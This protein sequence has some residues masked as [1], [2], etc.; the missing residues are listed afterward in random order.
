M[1][2]PGHFFAA[3]SLPNEVGFNRYAVV[4]SKKL[5]KSAA[6][7]NHKRRQFYETIRIWEQANPVSSAPSSDIVLLVRAAA[8]T[9]SF[10]DLQTALVTFLRHS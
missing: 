1:H 2:K 3:V 6:T 5:A 10:G 4:V 7:R 9:A 8:L